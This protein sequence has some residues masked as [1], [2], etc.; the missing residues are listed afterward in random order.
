[1]NRTEERD[2]F[3]INVGPESGY[4]GTIAEESAR[5]NDGGISPDGK[6]LGWENANQTK[7]PDG[8]P[9]C[10]DTSG[11]DGPPCCEEPRTKTGESRTLHTRKS[12]CNDAPDCDCGV[13]CGCDA[14]CHCA[15]GYQDAIFPLPDMMPSNEMGIPIPIP[16]VG[17]EQQNTQGNL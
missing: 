3:W 11:Y 8:V 2:N 10:H 9:Y 1:M 7:H 5:K 14:N 15:D 17:P 16:D 12:A 6:R 13:D 4:L